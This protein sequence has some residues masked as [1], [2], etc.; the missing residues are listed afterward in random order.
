MNPNVTTLARWLAHNAVKAELRAMGRRP[1]YEEIGEA[2]R[3]YFAEH[4]EALIEQAKAHP[5]LRSF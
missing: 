5:A 1:E 3:A 4:R 2:V